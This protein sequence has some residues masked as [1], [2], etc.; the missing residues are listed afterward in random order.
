M[1]S[2][3]RAIALACMLCL[4]G[5]C[6]VNPVTGERELSLISAQQEVAIGAQ[7]YRPS[8]QSQG[9][10]YTIDPEI[11]LYVAEVGHKLAAVSDRAAL[12]WEFTV[13]NNPVPNAWALPGGKIAINT[14]LLLQLEDESQLAAVLAHE[15]VHAAARHSASQMSRGTLINLGTQ[16][17]GIAAQNA[18]YGSLAGFAQLGGAAWMAR[19]SR[20]DELESDT[21]GMVYMSRAGYDPRGAV[22]LQE[23]FVRLNEDR[24]GDF[25]SNLFASHPP[26]PERVARNREQAARLPAGGARNRERYQREI[27]QLKK[28]EPAYEAMQKAVAALNDQDPKL[29]L[30]YLDRA[31]RIQPDDSHFWELR[32]HAWNQLDNSANAGKAFT[33]A[34]GKNPDL[35]SHYLARGVLRYKTGKTT[36]ARVDLEKSHQL[37]PTP[38]ASFYLGELAA[39]AGNRD[40]ALGYYRQAAGSDTQVGERARFRLVSLELASEPD[41][42]IPSRAFVGDNGYLQVLIQNNS[43]MPV[44]DIG[45]QVVKMQNAFTVAES[46]RLRGPARLEPGQ[47]AIVRTGI[48]PFDSAEAAG[49]FRSRV[50]GAR[51]AE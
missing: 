27:R 32:G 31:V 46:L 40:E 20:E 12:P 30:E 33:T 50:I 36:A 14:G 28:D 29:A 15:I 5:A 2:L 42:Y 8:L 38:T 44:A 1:I 39:D 26:S 51:P 4:L 19:Y 6:A 17:A 11:G 7:N 49:Q 23:T 9:G 35:F 48:G 18:G 13:L 47:Q 24:Q 10:R 37:L 34:I 3:F 25:F 45:I 41:K 22:E 43:G 16:V 21:Y